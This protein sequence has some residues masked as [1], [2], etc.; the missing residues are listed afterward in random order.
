MIEKYHETIP[1]FIEE[2]AGVRE[3]LRL[4]DIGMDCGCEY[5]SFS[6][7]KGISPYRRYEHS[8]G[9][10]L[11]VYHFTGD[12]KQTVAALFHDIASPVFA[13]VVDFMNN[14]YLTQESTESETRKIIEGSDEIR[15]LLDKYG[16]T[17]DD[18][19]DYH[20]YPVA[21]NDTPKLSAD[22]L[23]YTLVNMSRSLKVSDVI[24]T[25]IYKNLEVGI[26]EHGEE[27]L[28]F[29]DVQIARDFVL[30]ALRNSRNYVS[31]EDRYSMERLARLLRKAVN[32]NVI[33]MEDL[34]TTETEV[35]RKL[36]ESELTREDWL[37]YCD[38][39]VLEKSED[40]YDDR[41]LKIDA[42]KRYIDPYVK[43]KGRVSELSYDCKKKINDLLN[44]KF[45]YYLKGY[46]YAED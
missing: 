32:E 9:V 25:A 27:E 36:Q 38:M 4:K 31:D 16:L 2:F 6:L 40:Q 33:T 42:K 45:D 18:V 30:Y 44:Y 24:I 39:T 11:I 10:A 15:Q 3:M 29:R 12:I 7:W 43:G 19:A 28:M 41:W 22:R 1:G 5:T 26:N 8:L 23:E 34:Y 14:D 13:H 35:I 46:G 21:D 17:V 20:L 37:E